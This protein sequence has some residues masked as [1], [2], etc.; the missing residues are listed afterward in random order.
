MIVCIPRDM[1]IFKGDFAK[2][3]I[4]I[5]GMQGTNIDEKV[6]KMFGFLLTKSRYVQDFC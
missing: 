2:I 5:Y 4:K 3:S 6:F 1:Q